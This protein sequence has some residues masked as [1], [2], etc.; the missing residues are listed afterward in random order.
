MNDPHLTDEETDVVLA[1]NGITVLNEAPAAPSDPLRP[2][3][4]RLPDYVREMLE[5]PLRNIR[6]TH[7]EAVTMLRQRLSILENARQFGSSVKLEARIA[8][9]RAVLAHAEA[10]AATPTSEEKIGDCLV[11]DDAAA[12]HVVI[13]CGFDLTP[14]MVRRVRASG[15]APSGRSAKRPRKIIDGENDALIAARVLARWLNR[16]A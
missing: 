4:Q 8:R 12:G 16:A 6:A 15:F 5:K 1:L 10:L 3:Y 2:T 11:L 14:E 7:P 13:R 9:T